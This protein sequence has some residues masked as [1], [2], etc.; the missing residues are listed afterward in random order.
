M[1]ERTTHGASLRLTASSV[2][3][4]RSRAREL[5][6]DQVSPVPL[7]GNLTYFPA[8]GEYKREKVTVNNGQRKKEEQLRLL[9]CFWL[10]CCWRW[11][12]WCSNFRI[13]EDDDEEEEEGVEM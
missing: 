10:C 12:W 4:L 6:T 5:H 8:P 1:C 2:S 9:S 7:L 3:L 13:R 11:W